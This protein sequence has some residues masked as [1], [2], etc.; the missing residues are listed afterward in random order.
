MSSILICACI[1]HSMD[2]AEKG[3]E[4]SLLNY[5][6]RI[7]AALSTGDI[8]MIP[9]LIEEYLSLTR[10]SFL[11]ARAYWFAGKTYLTIP[12]DGA[13]VNGVFQRVPPLKRYR[14]SNPR[15][16]QRRWETLSSNDSIVLT[17]GAR[18][19]AYLERARELYAHFDTPEQLQRIPDPYRRRWRED[20]LRCLLDLAT[21]LARF[22]AYD[23][24]QAFW[25]LADISSTDVSPSI[26]RT[27]NWHNFYD[28]ILDARGLKVSEDGTP[29]FPHIPGRY[30]EC[31]TRES[32]LFF[33]LR[34]I[35]RLDETPHRDFAATALYRQAL[36]AENR[37]GIR[38]TSAMVFHTPGIQALP[39]KVLSLATERLKEGEVY[40]FVEGKL[41]KISLPSFLN[42]PRLLKEVVK[43][44][45][46]SSVIEKA[47]FA[48]GSIYTSRRQYARALKCYEDLLERFPR[49]KTA[50]LARK[51]VR[52]LSA[53][54][55]RIL[56]PTVQFNTT[57][58]IEIIYRNVDE[59]W[60]TARR[61]DMRAMVNAILSSVPEL[62]GKSDCRY[63]DLDLMTMLLKKEEIVPDNLK[64]PARR[65]LDACIG[66][67]IGRWRFPLP[68]G[69]RSET[70][71]HRIEVKLPSLGTYLLQAFTTPPHPATAGKKGLQGATLGGNRTLL[72]L[73]DTV[74]TLLE[75]GKRGCTFLVTDVRDGKPKAKIPLWCISWRWGRWG[76]EGHFHLDI[77]KTDEDGIVHLPATHVNDVFAFLKGHVAWYKAYGIAPPAVWSDTDQPPRK[78]YYGLIITDKKRYSPGETLRFC[79][80]VY[81]LQGDEKITPAGY[82]VTLLLRRESRKKD[83]EVP[84]L[85]D[86]YGRAY[87]KITLPRDIAGGWHEIELFCD[88]VPT[89]HKFCTKTCWEK[90]IAETNIHVVTPRQKNHNHKKRCRVTMER[91]PSSPTR[92]IAR[93]SSESGLPVPHARV[94]YRI[95]RRATPHYILLADRGWN[96]LYVSDYGIVQYPRP[97][98][99]WWKESQDIGRHISL[100]RYGG[101]TSPFSRRTFYNRD[102]SFVAKGLL[103]TDGDGTVTIDLERFHEGLRG[104]YEYNIGIDV[105]L[106]SPTGDSISLSTSKTFTLPEVP[107]YSLVYTLENFYFRHETIEGRVLCIDRRGKA[108]RTTGMLQVSRIRVK[109]GHIVEEKI[110]SRQLRTNRR[111]KA[112]FSFE[113]EKSG[114]LHISFTPDEGG[115][116]GHFLVWYG[117]LE[118]CP[119]LFH[120]VEIIPKKHTYRPGAKN[121]PILVRTRREEARVYLVSGKPGK[122]CDRSIV[123]T[124]QHTKLVKNMDGI[125][126]RENIPNTFL[127]GFTFSNGNTFFTA[128][129]VYLRHGGVHIELPSEYREFASN[130][131]ASFD[132][133]LEDEEGKPLKAEKAC[134]TAYTN[135]SP[136]HR[137]SLLEAVYRFQ[138]YRI[139]QL[140]P[141]YPA[142]TLSPRLREKKAHFL[143]Y[144]LCTL[145]AG[146]NTW[147]NDRAAT[148]YDNASWWKKVEELV[149]RWVPPQKEEPVAHWWSHI[150]VIHSIPSIDVS[151]IKALRYEHDI[152]DV[153]HGNT[154]ETL[155]WDPT[156]KA[157]SGLWFK[158]PRRPVHCEA[159]VWVMT[160]DGRIGTVST[161][162]YPVIYPKRR[163]EK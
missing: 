32:K 14:W 140:L 133:L 81:K 72:F 21:A 66:K 2:A 94:R 3:R 17:D 64:K 59:V 159:R 150:G 125:F 43:R 142:Y 29:L 147:W 141:P 40:T 35:R 25:Q 115:R 144:R 71:R 63:K 51:Y 68:K 4:T 44:Y 88:E 134:V 93:V 16:E 132:V 85:L 7:E 1:I 105:S 153:P 56:P 77:G 103:S 102:W 119:E 19:V 135:P 9:S 113:P 101:A 12:H 53:P 120:P 149:L 148:S 26:E 54:R 6:K 62:M 39:Q 117:D 139:S 42:A 114:A 122:R 37:F 152:D 87:G 83:I 151:P 100:G 15:R 5:E 58:R 104:D 73:T 49:G 145:G 126:R 84:L 50:P 121:E 161:R 45:P 60:I 48:L 10:D 55:V 107:F 91:D 80:W 67:E 138:P 116:R 82:E 86:R 69:E 20:R 36:L 13:K 156:I 109:D 92:V 131:D 52:A 106:P 46:H 18:A 22:G 108:V 129:P 136:W 47:L 8:D 130:E 99:P 137:R 143:F 24:H 97:M 75:Q 95:R 96:W 41:R 155:K 90:E 31:T 123:R 127:W 34:E 157:I 38:R 112:F 111:G 98:L 57:A 89:N 74:I 70:L 154:Q 118:A 76:H 78:G 162:L 158:L 28:A 79:V 160:R 11:E 124:E 110:F 128:V 23:I 146:F 163:E 30:Q 27:I 65:L 61:I 33:V